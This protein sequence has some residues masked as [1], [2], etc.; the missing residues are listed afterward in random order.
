MAKKLSPEREGK[1]KR[2]RKH[3]QT[4]NKPKIQYTNRKYNPLTQITTYKSVPL[5]DTDMR[6]GHRMFIYIYTYIEHRNLE[7]RKTLTTS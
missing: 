7:T 2:K 6:N 4:N 5:P 3:K 1:R